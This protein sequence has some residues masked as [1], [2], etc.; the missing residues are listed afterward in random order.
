MGESQ[1]KAYDSPSAA[2]LF[3]LDPTSEK[4]PTAKAK[5][6]HSLVAKLTNVDIN[7]STYRYFD[8]R[9]IFGQ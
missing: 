3:Q 2:D 5:L 6:Y 8:D 4:L 1:I 7:E 9:G